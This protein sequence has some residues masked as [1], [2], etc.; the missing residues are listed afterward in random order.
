LFEELIRV[1]LIIRWPRRFPAGHTVDVPVSGVDLFPTICELAGATAIPPNQ[2]V[3]LAAVARAGETASVRRVYSY[4]NF[5]KRRMESVREGNVKLIVDGVADQS[6][7]Y[8]LARDPAEKEN[9]VGAETA[10][11]RRLTR[12]L[13]DQRKTSTR[14]IAQ[15]GLKSP[16]SPARLSEE[17][18]RQLRGLGY[19]K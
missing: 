13:N 5:G 1:P 9:L 17:T 12:L 7:L 2:G 18:I 8:D 19:W 11:A 4:L 10:V 6:L 14:L 15:M 16:S 3:Q